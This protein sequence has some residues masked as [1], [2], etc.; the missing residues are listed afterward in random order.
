MCLITP[1][2][3]TR[4]NVTIADD[5][6][7]AQAGAH[8][9]AHRRDRRAGREPE[10]DDPDQQQR[11]RV[12]GCRWSTGRRSLVRSTPPGTLMMTG[13]DDARD[14]RIAVELHDAPTGQGTSP[15]GDGRPSFPGFR[16]LFG[17]SAAFAAS[18]TSNASAEGLA[19]EPGCG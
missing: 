3:C 11:T 16:T 2:P 14:E 8:L 10:E 12:T 4:T 13:G 18:K 19:H 15:K 6:A 1:M 9:L 17:S 7:A 5:D